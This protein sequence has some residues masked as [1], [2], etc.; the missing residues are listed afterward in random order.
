ML[1]HVYNP[2]K[3]S[4]PTNVLP[5]TASGALLTQK[6]PPETP[7][8]S[9]RTWDDRGGF[10]GA[11]GAIG[12]VTGLLKPDVAYSNGCPG[13]RKSNENGVGGGIGARVGFMYMPINDPTVA[14]GNFVTFR[15]GFGLDADF[16]Y[17]REPTGCELGGGTTGKSRGLMFMSVPIEVGLGYA[18][19]H[20]I[21]KTAWRGVIV[22]IAYAPAAQF[23]MDLSD[24]LGNGNG[25]FLFNP[26]G[27]QITVDITKF[28]VSENTDP[29]MQIR[30][31]VWGL[32]PLDIDHPGLLSL[33]VGAIWY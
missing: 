26:A 28:N 6:P 18:G 13:V 5:P 3:A 1:P 4:S 20:F 31:S 17:A 21:E 24:K 33:G 10:R 30:L 14:T 25:K 2:K 11:Y 23:W 8:D 22:G 15:G 12:H 32:V 9:Q 7:F 16:F 27:A 19:G 29:S